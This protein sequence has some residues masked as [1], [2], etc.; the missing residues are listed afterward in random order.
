M[1]IN[2]LLPYIF[3][4]FAAAAAVI[5]YSLFMRRI[6]KFF[7]RSSTYIS[8][9]CLTF[10]VALCDS[11]Y[12]PTSAY[13]AEVAKETA[14]LKYPQVPQLLPQF[15]REQINNISDAVMLLKR[16]HSITYKDFPVM[17]QDTLAIRGL[18]YLIEEQKTHF[19]P[20]RSARQE[21]IIREARNLLSIPDL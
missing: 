21:E 9:L 16:R 20:T 10:A 18:S 11:L 12:G 13:Q 5:L 1:V 19:Y 3:L 7:R 4:C 8:I 15:S 17:S 6:P 14:R 2:I